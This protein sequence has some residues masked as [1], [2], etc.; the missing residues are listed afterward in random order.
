MDHVCARATLA[1]PKIVLVSPNISRRQVHTYAFNFC[2]NWCIRSQRRARAFVE[3]LLYRYC[4]RAKAYREGGDE[5]AEVGNAR[6]LRSSC[7]VVVA[8]CA[9]I[10]VARTAPIVAVAAA[11]VRVAKGLG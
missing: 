5:D 1:K 8:A 6:A 3:S 4:Y 11:A 2:S 7:E 9:A 10:R